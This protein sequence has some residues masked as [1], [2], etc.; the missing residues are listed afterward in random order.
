M[1][2]QNESLRTFKETVVLKGDLY[3]DL[4]KYFYDMV[5]RNVFYR[6]PR[7]YACNSEYRLG[8]LLLIH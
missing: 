2:E 1:Q 3:L 7:N 5:S 4:E 6:L 8:E